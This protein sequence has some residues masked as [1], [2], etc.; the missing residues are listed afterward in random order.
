[1]KRR[2]F[3]LVIVLVPAM[4]A[5][6]GSDKTGLSFKNATEC[7]TATINI[8]DTSTGN[9]K[10]LTVDQGKSSEV[11]LK[12][13]V[14]YRYTVE[15]P[16]QPGDLQCDKKEVETILQSGQM[17]HI[18]LESVLAPELETTQPAASSE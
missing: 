8:T 14:T 16:K 6:C 10:T 11:K 5:A 4:L 12:S 18:T 15:Y 13:K 9:I 1:M 7:G 3:L 2:W 17:L